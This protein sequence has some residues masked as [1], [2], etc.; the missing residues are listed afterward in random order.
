MNEI[1]EDQEF[2]DST[3][4]IDN[5]NVYTAALVCWNRRRPTVGE[6]AEGRANGSVL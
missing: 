1:R 3:R 5:Q 4:H 6:A 2:S